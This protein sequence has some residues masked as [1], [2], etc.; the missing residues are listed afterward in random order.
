MVI[1]N[2]LAFNQDSSCLSVSTST[3]H[4][5]FNCEPFGEFYLSQK[6]VTRRSLSKSIDKDKEE[7]KKELTN[8]TEPRAPSPTAYV[9]MLFS[10]SLVIIIPDGD[11]SNRLLKIYNSKQNIKICDLNFPAHIIDIRLNR[12]RLVVALQLGQIYLYDLG[13]VR[14]I[15]ILEMAP[16]ERFVGDLN[17]SDNSLLVLPLEIVTEKSDMFDNAF[18]EWTQKSKIPKK[19]RSNIS[20]HDLKKDGHGWLI[21]YDTMNLQPKL[22]FK[23]HDSEIAKIK[24]SGDVPM[25]ASA[26]VKGTI[27]RVFSLLDEEG[28]HLKLVTNLRRGHN[29]ARINA[30]NFNSERT[31]LGCA[32]ASST[33][34][35]FRLSGT[36]VYEEPESDSE[37]ETA[38]RSS[39]QDLSENL[40][41]LLL[42]ED[43]QD[44]TSDGYFSKF[45]K[46]SKLINN[47]YTKSIIKKLPYRDYLENL[48]WEPPRR[49]FAYIKLP[50]YGSP[51][52]SRVEIGFNG[53]MVL[54]ALYQTGNF[55]QY[56]MPAFVED[57]EERE[58]CH[59][60][61]QFR[62]L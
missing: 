32:S 34:H 38:S 15:K 51:D 13:C 30:L 6:D 20:L 57:D 49:S 24:I 41:N 35:L 45:K 10:T 28:F 40:S 54:L 8:G 27:L 46:S 5:I 55:Y 33:V 21:V 23:A 53:Q 12:K 37:P 59:L 39:S 48:I 16:K 62:L 31:V 36:P 42:V 18:I 9:R 1:I 2:D 19:K 17:S 52:E 14:L 4:K 47:L 60:V 61:N 26:S 44:E 3:Y 22:I 25:I 11:T 50:E 58:E 43:T 56:Q 7:W 29:P